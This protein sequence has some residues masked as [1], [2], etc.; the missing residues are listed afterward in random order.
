MAEKLVLNPGSEF[1]L[2]FG[3][4]KHMLQEVIGWELI[5][6]HYSK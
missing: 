3:N 5:I 6:H 2:I 4:Q 1:F